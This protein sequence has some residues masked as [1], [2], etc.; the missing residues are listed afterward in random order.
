MADANELA[1][2]GRYADQYGRGRNTARQFRERG[3][4]NEVTEARFREGEGQR[5][6]G[7]RISPE[8][9]ACRGLDVGADELAFD[10]QANL[11]ELD[12]I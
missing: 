5:G 12:V 7:S 11:E 2:A 8:E 4:G 9:L 1:T 3:A 10:E 6:L